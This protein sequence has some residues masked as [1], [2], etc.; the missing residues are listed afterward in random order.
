MADADVD[1]ELTVEVRL[2]LEEEVTL[3]R[4]EELVLLVLDVIV[5]DE[6]LLDFE[7]LEVA[8]VRH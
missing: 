4:L 5:D 6:A 1:A 8:G 2:V 3:V 7:V